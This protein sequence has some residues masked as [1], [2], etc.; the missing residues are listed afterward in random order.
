MFTG[1]VQAYVSVAAIIEKPGLI[2]FSLIFPDELRVGLQ[3]GASVAVDG[4]CFTT[5]KVE[6]NQV[7]F[8]A[9]QETLQRTTIGLLKTGQFVNVERSFKIGD[10]VGGHLL[11]GHVHGMAEI[12]SIDTSI[13]NNQV[14]T[15]KIPHHLTKYIFT[16]GFVALNGV[17]LTLVEVDKKNATFT[18]YFI[19]ETWKRTTFGSK[20]VGDWVNIEIDSQTQAIV[21][22]VERILAEKDLNSTA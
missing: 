14:V 10:E 18:V 2:T 16:K 6:H 19:P 22:T 7:F 3:T 20:Q 5:V 12:T 9:M 8:D 17:S 4:V 21:E 1:I 15:F 13:P 11:S